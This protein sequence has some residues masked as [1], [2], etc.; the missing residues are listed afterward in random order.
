VP[1]PVKRER[2]QRLL[3]LG[4][5]LAGAYRARFHGSERP[6]LWEHCDGAQR[7]HGDGAQRETGGR[8]S[9]LTDNYIRVYASGND[10]F[11]RITPARL[12]APTG[13]GV[14]GDITGG[15]P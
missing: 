8:W 2:M 5:D 1:E 6:V 15:T 9:G 11:N 3:A 13:D 7:E 14:E 10:L 12:G 4:D